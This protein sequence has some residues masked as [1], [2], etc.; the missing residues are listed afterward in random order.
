MDTAASETVK[1]NNSGEAKE[2]VKCLIL[3]SGPAGYTAAIYAARANLNPVMY[4]GMQIGGQLTTTTEVE[5]YPGYPEGVTGPVMMEDFKKQA[6]RFG[7]DTRWGMATSVDF[8]KRPFKVVIDEETTIEAESVIIATGAT[9]KY[10][11]LESEKAFMGYGVSACATCD[12]FF[13][14]GMDVAVVGGGDTALEEA[15]YLSGI[16]RKVYL[17]HRRDELRG[18]KIMQD[19]LLAKENIEVMWNNVPKEVVGSKTVEGVILENTKTGEEKRIDVAGFFV[20]IGHK[21]N[22][23]I[24][25]DYLDTDEVGYINTIANTSRTNVPGVF[26][27][28]DVMDNMYRQAVTAAGSGCKA[29]ID[30]ERWLG[31]EGLI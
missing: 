13:Y 21:P 11:G 1:T 6:Q 27:C 31:E 4:E 19:R 8:S 25:A 14:K 7:T 24:F 15:L 30:T 2:K 20:A 28:G 29:A 12:G 10:I 23:D 26:A 5:N 18:S 16:C 9:A 3:G 22:S 17:I